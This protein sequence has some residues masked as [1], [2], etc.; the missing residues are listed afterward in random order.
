[1]SRVKVQMD[2]E[3]LRLAN[4]GAGSWGVEWLRGLVA[5]ASPMAAREYLSQ[6]ADRGRILGLYRGLFPEEFRDSHASIGTGTARFSWGGEETPIGSY[7]AREWE[8]FKLVD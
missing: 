7:S 6:L 1:M 5:S 3:L 2:S 4:A 8:F